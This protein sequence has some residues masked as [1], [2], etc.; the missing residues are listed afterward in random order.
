MSAYYA[1]HSPIYDATRWTFLHGRDAIV[2]DLNPKPGDV[3][4]EIGCGTGRNLTNIRK[5]VGAEGIVLGVDCA[6]AMIAVAKRRIGNNG[7][8]NVSVLEREY[9]AAPGAPGQVDAILLSYS[10]SMIPS[11]PRIIH[12]A[13]EELRPGGRIGVVDFCLDTR[14]AL[15]LG[16]SRWLELN[17]VAVDRPYREQLS[18]VL[19]PLR[20]VTQQAFGGLWSFYRF[21]GERTGPLGPRRASLETPEFRITSHAVWSVRNSSGFR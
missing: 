1:W 3:V 20:C 7:W 21:L 5:R 15:T 12:C 14:N 4:L 9:G 11:W 18:S 2:E 8:N 6:R 19:S 10:L 13:C 16:F 17:H